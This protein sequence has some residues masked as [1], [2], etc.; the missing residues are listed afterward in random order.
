MNKQTITVHKKDYEF[1]AKKWS[2]SELLLA[3]INGG[4]RKYC[5]TQHEDLCKLAAAH[6]W[7]MEVVDES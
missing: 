1:W 3:H 4:E 6:G 2:D 7:S 5:V